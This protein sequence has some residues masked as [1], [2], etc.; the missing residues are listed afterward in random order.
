MYL[1]S[2]RTIPNYIDLR[3]YKICI[4]IACEKSPVRSLSPLPPPP[5]LA[6]PSFV[7]LAKP[8]TQTR[9]GDDFSDNSMQFG[10]L[11]IVRPNST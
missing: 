6:T 1:S 2:K 9:S 5:P 7:Y 8:L 3:Q 11:S 4:G 10:R